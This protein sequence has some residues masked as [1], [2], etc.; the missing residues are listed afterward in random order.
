[1]SFV[2][3]NVCPKRQVYSRWRE[4]HQGHVDLHSFCCREFQ[5]L[6]QVESSENTQR[7]TVFLPV[8]MCH[9]QSTHNFTHSFTSFQMPYFLHFT[10]YI[11]EKKRFQIISCF[12]WRPC[13]LFTP[14]LASYDSPKNHV[15][16]CLLNLK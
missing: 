16:V 10:L 5:S 11:N 14:L 1:M 7:C 9:F 8:H 12:S 4:L 6:C 13:Y 3:Q 2:E 15:C